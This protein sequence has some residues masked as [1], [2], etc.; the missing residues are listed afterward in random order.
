M[1][2]TI[3]IADDHPIVR[4]GIRNLLQPES[5][6]SIVGEV[7]DG[8][9]AI[10]QVERLK[11]DILLLDLMLPGLSGLE[12]LR[13]ARDR[14]PTTRVVVLS[15]YS[16]TAF[17]AE[18]LKNGASAYVLKGSAEDD[19]VRGLRDVAHG[20]RFLSP[21]ISDMAIEG[22]IEL[23]RDHPSD[24]HETLTPRERE[25]LQLA[26]EGHTNSQIAQRL[27][28]SPRTVENHRANLLR[29]LGITN[30]SELVVYA[31]RHGLI[32]LDPPAVGGS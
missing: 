14:T 1:S 5:E 10:H 20:K 24:P 7:A 21:Q 18:A 32:P 16:T 23:L 12:V 3:L 6:F 11:P 4:R 22:Y 27:H 13:V 2:R 29:K 28:I 9:E 26:A 31:V 15:M 30:H 19:I 17:V 8:L 25:I